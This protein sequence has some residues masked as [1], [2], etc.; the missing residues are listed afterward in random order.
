LST[1]FDNKLIIK[2][3][4]SW[5]IG[6]I[7]ILSHGGAL[8]IS[9]IVPLPWAV[10]LTLLGLIAISLYQ[11]VRRYALHKGEQTIRWA[12][13]DGDGEWHL[14]LGNAEVLGPCSVKGHYAKPWL[15]LVRL[16]SPTKRM[17]LSLVVTPDAVDHEVFKN[18][19]VRLNL[20]VPDS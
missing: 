17:P 12:E 14:G 10:R 6:S 5:T 2:L 20:A 18:L 3:K 1:N 11:S 9:T 15:I 7:L 4:R 13:L 8:A 16:V 19:Q